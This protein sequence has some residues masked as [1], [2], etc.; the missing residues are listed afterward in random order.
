MFLLLAVLSSQRKVSFPDVVPAMANELPET[1]ET[2]T[3]EM[4]DILI[5]SDLASLDQYRNYHYRCSFEDKASN[6]FLFQRSNK[7]N[8]VSIDA[9]NKRM[10]SLA[11]HLIS[12][13]YRVSYNNNQTEYYILDNENPISSQDK[14]IKDFPVLDGF[15]PTFLVYSRYQRTNIN[16]FCHLPKSSTKFTLSLIIIVL[17]VGILIY[18]YAQKLN[19]DLIYSVVDKNSKILSGRP[20]P[21]KYKF[22]QEIV[23][24]NVL[25]AIKEQK[26]QNNMLSFRR[27]MG[28]FAFNWIVYIPHGDVCV[29]FCIDLYC[30][31]KCSNIQYNYLLEKDES[32]E[33]ISQN[34]RYNNLDDNYP[35]TME[36]VLHDP[37]KKLSN[38]QLGKSFF[39]KEDINM[40]IYEINK[41]PNTENDYKLDVT[42][43]SF[44]YPP[45]QPLGQI[46]AL[47]IVTFH[48]LL[49]LLQNN[50]FLSTKY[51]KYLKIV[52]EHMKISRALLVIRKKDKYKIIWQT[53]KP[54]FTPIIGA[55]NEKKIFELLKDLSVG[56][57]TFGPVLPD[58]Q[59]ALVTKMSSTSSDIFV[60]CGDE[61]PEITPMYQYDILPA[62]GLM[63]SLLYD[64]S[65][66]H[67]HCCQYERAL[68]FFESSKLFAYFELKD[69]VIIQFRGSMGNVA[70]ET[71]D[72][73]DYSRIVPE[74]RQ[75]IIDKLDD[76]VKNGTPMTQ[77]V[78]EYYK[79]GTSATNY[80][81]LSAIRT[82]PQPGQYVANIFVEDISAIKNQE[83]DLIEA[84]AQ[85]QLAT[86]ALGL[87][88]FIYQDST[89]YLVDDKLFA[90]I[91]L[92]PSSDLQL[93]P[94]VYKDDLPKL[95]H[96]TS[97]IS[98]IRL[99]GLKASQGMRQSTTAVRRREIANIAKQSMNSSHESPVINKQANNSVTL[100]LVD[101]NGNCVWYSA[102][103]DGSTGFIFSVDSTVK[104]RRQLQT[105][106]RG[107]KIASATS[108]FT[109]WGVDIETDR[110][111]RLLKYDSLWDALGVEQST[112][113]TQV[114]DYCLEG[115]EEVQEMINMMKAGT[116]QSWTGD[117]L[118]L[119]S[120]GPHWYRAVVTSSSKT[121]SNCFM[122]DINEQ[123]EM[124]AQLLRS[125]QLRDLI[126]TSA[127]LA[128]WTFDD[129]HD[130]AIEFNIT[131]AVKMNWTFV[132]QYIDPESKEDFTDAVY[133]ALEEQGNIDTVI[134]IDEYWYSIRGRYAADSN[135]LIG[136]CCDITEL[137][138]AY[139]DLARE[140]ERAQNANKGK[141]TFL[142]NM[143]HEI[144]TPM[145]GIVG[146]LDIL[147]MHELTVEQRLLTDAIRTSSFELMKQ[148]SETLN[149]SRI[150]QGK[151][152]INNCIFDISQV[153]EPVAV[154][155]AT[156]ARLNNLKLHF[157]VT[158][159]TPIL[160]Y[161]ES[162]M[163]LQIVNNLLS[164]ALKFTKN[165]MV[166]VDVSWETDEEQ[167]ENLVLEVS[168]SGIGMSDEQKQMIFKRFGQGDPNVARFYGGTGLGLALV[169]DLIAGLGGSI[170]FDSQCG[171]GTQFH[172]KL[173]FQ[174]ILCPYSVPFKEGVHTILIVCPEAPDTFLLSFLEF[175]KYSTK[176]VKTVEEVMENITN[177][178]AVFVDVEKCGTELSVQIRNKVKDIQNYPPL[179][180]L[181]MPGATTEYP[182]SLT[183]PLLP[184][185]M[186]NFIGENR[187]SRHEAPKPPVV[188]KV[189]DI[190]GTQVLVVEDNH[191]NQFVMSKMLTKLKC[192]FQIA[193]NGLQALE[194]LEN[195]DE[196][197]NLVFMDCQMPV[198]D[199]LEATKRIRAADG[200]AYQ[201]VPI[202]ALT[203]SAIEGDEEK[204]E[205]AGMNGY[206]A[207]PVR[208][209]QI[210]DA[211]KK[212][213]K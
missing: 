65:F 62:F 92:A 33:I 5:I 93:A 60:L 155:S 47:V 185:Q 128:L 143:S 189:D 2:Q 187:F 108:M 51:I 61:F 30:I 203:A 146:M 139:N 104:M 172:V 53:Q 39:N 113:Y 110:V 95:N 145:N 177:V 41:V 42:I 115:R 194:K 35:V 11:Y 71:K 137:K 45:F 19:I 150:E 163:F 82:E 196:K 66:S 153:L 88:K 130:E 193:D 34:K 112:P 97:S 118:L 127:K 9:N 87:H 64:L 7:N 200:K 140:Q 144:R 38:A 132:D 134:K 147:A 85:L 81:S 190:S 74:I 26:I 48:K 114:V 80:I 29:C 166:S 164:N 154:A 158:P 79:K 6:I 133:E 15:S 152:Q 186:R 46:F 160:V 23:N 56:Y 179:Y 24:E 37:K 205:G 75:T 180:A 3:L 40:Q 28:K 100:R 149:M 68:D 77:I 168:D 116:L 84:H 43:S 55:A 90:E 165:G 13:G 183:K 94:L 167:N 210:T 178:D 184:R 27:N 161:G 103:S 12:N 119:T 170:T 111:E 4:P 198:M 199:G 117:V 202:I 101:V 209:Q 59:K 17:F 156:R 162:Q 138:T 25:K 122:M 201:A 72:F 136:I 78:V 174:S 49:H 124:E 204:C 175:Y 16:Q 58:C 109:F 151:I 83:R 36:Y 192:K 159:N 10:D 102:V 135:R 98:F 126:L 121:H 206:L 120:R 86:D 129:N 125:Q 99:N 141:T 76:L 182:K 148:L 21:I 20:L 52:V 50:P 188:Q 106:E 91:G 176:V 18:A 1:H 54:G 142:A 191:V 96:K 123:K 57:H 169:Q 105:T 8:E 131:H 73:R 171:V 31:K 212:Y 181:C 195:S 14:I 67:Q 208:I 70:L 32:I 211:I 69:D 197:F 157:V 213:A 44:S 22:Q 89:I 173:P 107:L 207:K 63:T